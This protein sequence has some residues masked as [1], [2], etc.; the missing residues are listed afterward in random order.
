MNATS[1]QSTRCLFIG[2]ILTAAHLIFSPTSAQEDREADA[3]QAVTTANPAVPVE[4]LELRLKPLRQEE[5]ANEAEGW[6][7]LLEAKVFEISAAEIAVQRKNLEIDR[8]EDLEEIVDN[9]LSAREHVRQIA[10][11]ESISEMD[12][13]VA[14]AVRS[15]IRHAQQSSSSRDLQSDSSAPGGTDIPTDGIDH[16]ADEA[17]DLLNVNSLTELKKKAEDVEEAKEAVRALLFEH[18]DALRTDRSAIIERLQTVLEAWKAKGGEVQS[19]DLYIE[20]VDD[21]TVDTSD[22]VT[23]WTTMVDWLNSWLADVRER[24]SEAAFEIVTMIFI[25]LAVWIAIKVAIKRKLGPEWEETT[26]APADGD[27]G[28]V[29]STR[30]ETL[31]PLMRKFVSITLI[32]IV[33]I[34]SLASLGINVAPLIAGAGMVG[35]AIGFGAQALV[36]DVVSGIF[37]SSTTPS[38]WEN[39]WRSTTFAARWRKSRCVHCSFATTTDRCIPFPS[40][41]SGI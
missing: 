2:L 3:S 41:R 25:A 12:A 4:E 14:R 9:G 1:R 11:L 33:V 24:L 13:A 35:I 6:L 22:T 8:I 26:A 27:G 31:L 17:S 29:G 37:F 21:V 32:I 20:A 23:L 36:R 30:V 18:L 40:A 28:G 34:M 7:A 39:T 5:L 19:F 38:A 16:T 10:E 15:A